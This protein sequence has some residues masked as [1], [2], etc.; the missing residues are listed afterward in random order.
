MLDRRDVNDEILKSTIQFYREAVKS[1][2]C[3]KCFCFGVTNS[4][5]SADL[6]KFNMPS[7]LGEEGS[8][9]VGVTQSLTGEITIEKKEIHKQFYYNALRNGASV[10]IHI[11]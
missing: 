10:C 1:E 9:L 6:Y 3:L 7:N 2:D 4:C 8:M 11:L 5:K